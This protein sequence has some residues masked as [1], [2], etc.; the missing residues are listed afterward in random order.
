MLIIQ[1][2]K[3]KMVLNKSTQRHY[4]RYTHLLK[5]ETCNND[6]YKNSREITIYIFVY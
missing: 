2:S 4:L 3:T 1:N 5:L 6:V